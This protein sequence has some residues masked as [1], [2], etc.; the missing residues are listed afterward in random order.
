MFERVSEIDSE[1]F[2]Q[3]I[4][5]RVDR[6]YTLFFNSQKSIV[7]KIQNR[8]DGDDRFTQETKDAYANLP[9]EID[10]DLANM[11]A[12]Y[13]SFAEKLYKKAMRHLPDDAKANF[14]LGLT[15]DMKKRVV[16]L[17]SREASIGVNSDFQYSDFDG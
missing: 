14:S 6:L 17:N 7:R 9:E 8:V 13:D 12:A 10:E 4:K 5:G 3:D 1:E 16:H 11:K 15:R 2:H